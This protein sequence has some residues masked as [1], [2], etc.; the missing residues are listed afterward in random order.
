MYATV[1]TWGTVLAVIL[2][3]AYFGTIISIAKKHKIDLAAAIDKA[4]TE[5]PL[6]SSIV[7]LL[8]A[9]LPAS[10]KPIATTLGDAIAKA[11]DTAELLKNASVVT[12]DQRKETAMSLITAALK[13]QG[14]TPDDKT[15]GAISDAV[16]IA[17]RVLVAHAA[18]VATPSAA[19][20]APAAA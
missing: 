12:P 9:A 8:E 4:Q 14:I 17:A 15:T 20:P 2:L 1:M 3:V 19:S 6:L 18:P 10:V 16:D 11:V 13:A 5:L 7:N